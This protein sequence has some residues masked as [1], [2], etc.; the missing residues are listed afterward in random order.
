MSHLETGSH[1]EEGGDDIN[2]IEVVTERTLLLSG[3][4]LLCGSDTI[5]SLRLK[6]VKD[7]RLLLLNLTGFCSLA[8]AAEGSKHPETPA[9]G[10]EAA[11]KDQHA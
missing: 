1:L 8:S 10:T 3:S 9:A 11:P 4:H 5:S 6:T 2:G 7:Q